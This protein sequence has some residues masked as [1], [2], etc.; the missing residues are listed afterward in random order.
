MND[1]PETIT[2][3]EMQEIINLAMNDRQCVTGT[4]AT[5]MFIMNR[6]RDVLTPY[7]IIGSGPVDFPSVLWV[8]HKWE[9]RECTD[10]LNGDTHT[11]Y[12]PRITAHAVNIR[13][14]IAPG[15]GHSPS[16]PNR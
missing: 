15:L 6:S 3:Y 14:I 8:C 5:G 12:T 10:P 1:K 13:I 11:E 7:F 2:N 9:V 4:T 16:M